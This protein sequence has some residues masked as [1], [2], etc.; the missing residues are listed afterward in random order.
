MAEIELGRA[1]AQEAA[2]AA[3]AETAAKI[4]L[5]ATEIEEIKVLHCTVVECV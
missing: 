1:E 2:K 3:M 5:G 4:E